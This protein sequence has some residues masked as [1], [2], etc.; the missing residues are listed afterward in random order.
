MSKFITLE[1]IDEAVDAIHSYTKH[2]P[3]IGLILGTGLG[4][5]AESVSPANI[6]HQAHLYLIR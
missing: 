4:G 2:K 5:M 6:I 3:K 1:M